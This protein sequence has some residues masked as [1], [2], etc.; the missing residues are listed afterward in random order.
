VYWYALRRIFW[1]LPTL[2]VVFTVVFFV[3]RV[4]AGDPAVVI[5][6]EYATA[7][8][9]EKIRHQLG[10]DQ[11][12]WVQ[13]GTSLVSLLRA[14][15]GQSLINNQPI[16]PQIF[17]VLP[18]TIE[19]TAAGII[20]GILLGVPLGIIS[21][22]RRN[23][24]TD[25]LS[26]IFSLVGLSAPSFYLGILLLLFFAMKLGWFPIIGF[27]HSGGIAR[28]LNHLFLP[29][30]SLGLTFAAFMARMSR[31]TM[32]EKLSADYVRTARSKGVPEFKVIFKHAL[33]DSLIS[34][35]TVIGIYVGVLMGGSIL[36][37]MVFSR[38]GLGKFLVGAIWQRDYNA[39]QSGL[40]MYACIIVLVNLTIDLLY[41]FID[42]RVKYK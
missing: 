12:I 33:R 7:E 6:G 31:S 3:M 26:R 1:T 41:G 20:I 29:A 28:R 32:L 2:F 21:A 8:S 17:Q 42:P 19:L 22:I 25:Y 16:A 38:P 5:L 13:Y 24:M 10:L 30:L 18:Y 23:R 4:V 37:E 9:L 27:S 35:V 34:I 14:D 15:F 11:P 39:I 40:V 36:T